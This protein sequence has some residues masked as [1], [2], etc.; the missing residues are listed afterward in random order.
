MSV[1]QSVLTCWCSTGL[2]RSYHALGSNSTQINYHFFVVTFLH[3][4]AKCIFF[5][6]NLIH[7]RFLNSSLKVPCIFATNRNVEG[8]NSDGVIVI[9]ID[10]TPRPYYGP[11]VDTASKRNEYQK[12]FPG[13]KAAGV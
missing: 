1:L 11:G 13:L 4:D 3:N 10:I 5:L 7:C 6:V 12:C 9:F 2:Q 8:S